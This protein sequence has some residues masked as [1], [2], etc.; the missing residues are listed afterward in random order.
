MRAVRDPFDRFIEKC[1]QLGPI[2]EERPALG[3]CWQWTGA[4]NSHGYG[5]FMAV[6]GTT[7]EAHRWSYRHH[8][9]EPPAGYDVDHLCRNRLCVNP[10]HLEAV[11]R[12]ENLLRGKTLVAAEAAV[13]ACPQGH[14]YD[15]VNTYRAPGQPNQRKCRQCRSERSRN[16]RT[17]A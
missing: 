15:K 14:P 8:V 9:G 17:A 1:D 7:V 11:T 3:R 13:T 4:V 6:K 5:N 10:S 16:R 12:R 2:P